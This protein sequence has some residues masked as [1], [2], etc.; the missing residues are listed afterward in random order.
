MDSSWLSNADGTE[1]NVININVTHVLHVFSTDRYNYENDFYK[2]GDLETLV[3]SEKESSCYNNYLNFIN[4][5][6]NGRYEVE[7]PF[8]ENHPVIHDHFILCKKRLCNTFTRLKRNPEL[9]KQCDN[10][11]KQQLKTGIIE[12]INEEGVVGKTH[13]IPHHPIIRNDQTTT[14]R[15]FSTIRIDNF[16][17]LLIKN[18]YDN[19]NNVMHKAWVTL[20]R[21][22]S[23]KNII[24]DLIPSLSA[25]SLTNSLKHFISRSGCPDNLI[26]DNGSNFVMIETQNF[27]SNLNI[28]WYFSL[29]LASW[30][31]FFL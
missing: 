30:Q 12:E 31:G 5:N 25:N 26:I 6:S 15:A 19:A 7:L 3:I 2:F 20:Y 9:L 14:K 23:T 16:G 28:K 13:Y 18:V 4:K 22:A 11:F 29:A 17:L 24:L 1:N 8:K 10:I 21:C 27:A